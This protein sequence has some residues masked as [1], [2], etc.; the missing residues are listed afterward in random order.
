MQIRLSVIAI[1]SSK[2]VRAD[3]AQIMT[4]VEG[5]D[6]FERNIADG[7]EDRLVDGGR[8]DVVMVEVDPEEP[9]A[10]AALETYLGQKILP[11]VYAISDV[12]NADMLRRL[13]R[14]GVKD[15]FA[16]PAQRQ[17]ILKVLGALLSD[18]RSQARSSGASITSVCSFINAKGGS[19]GTFLA[20]NTACAIAAKHKLKV[21]LLDFDL[22]FGDCAMLL[23]L[24]S[25]NNMTDA[26]RQADRLD[27]VFL[28]ALMAEHAS[29]V[30]VLASPSSLNTPTNL[31]TSAVRRIIDAATEVYDVVIV[32]LPRDI[33]A[34]TIEAMKAS[35]TTFVVLQ[36][37]LAT[38][39]DARLLVDHLPRCGIEPQRIELINNR[40]MA[41]AA[42]VSIDQL[43]QTL[44][45][46]K[47]HRVRN[48]FET[49]VAAEDQG[50]PVS[51]V[52]DRSPLSKDVQNL[53][54]YIVKAHGLVES[55]QKPQGLLDRLLHPNSGKKP[56]GKAATAK[57][58]AAKPAPAKKK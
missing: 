46:D 31:Q 7:I 20:V 44:K 22:Q 41:R 19:G 3:L 14:A 45:H 21:A 28:K 2:S 5:I 24:S 53:A 23:D 32:D 42:S 52:D 50:I 33:N 16:R 49:A 26:L 47:A 36:N 51:K 29:G 58:A 35:T 57:S 18:K 13:M 27:G 56:A 30:H 34:W 8:A 9:E 4:G 6:L 11:A 39:R 55:K 12:G 38:I 15:V 1:T 48:D 54:D 40:A 43:K 17:E 25:Q 10:F 37:N